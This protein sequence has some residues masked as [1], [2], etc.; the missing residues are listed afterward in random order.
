[1]T[2]IRV[3]VMILAEFS[4][5]EAR[6]GWKASQARRFAHGWS[7]DHLAWRDPADGPL[8]ATIRRRRWPRRRRI[9][10]TYGLLDQSE[11]L[12]PWS[13]WLDSAVP[14]HRS[15]DRS[16]GPSGEQPQGHQQQ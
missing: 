11:T 7:D 3:G 13:T 14:L 6:P 9:R 8:Y 2:G 10:L 4:W 16:V 1:M 12:R 5:R 15:A